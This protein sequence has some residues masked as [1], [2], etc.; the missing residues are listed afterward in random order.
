M[1]RLISNFRRRPVLGFVLGLCVALIWSCSVGG[2]PQV[3]SLDSARTALNDYVLPKIDVANETVPDE[4]AARYATDQFEEP[5]PDVANAEHYNLVPDVA[6][7]P[8]YGAQPGG[9]TPS[10]SRF[11]ALLKKPTSIARTSA[12]WWR[13]LKPLTSDRKPCLPVQ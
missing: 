9:T 13:S 1:K 8:L 6:N 5:L 7:Y 10:M 11:L 12:G 2:P 4:A 3:D